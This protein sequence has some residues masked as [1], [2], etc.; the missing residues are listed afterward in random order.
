[1]SVWCNE[2]WLCE[3]KQLKVLFFF[4]KMKQRRSWVHKTQSTVLEEYIVWLWKKKEN[5]PRLG[6]LR[7]E[8]KKIEVR[9]TF[10][11]KCIGL[12]RMI[13]GECFWWDSLFLSMGKQHDA[14]P[15][16]EELFT[17]DNDRQKMFLYSR[18]TEN[19][20]LCMYV[21][22][23]EKSMHVCLCSAWQ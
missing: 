16:W 23:E 6:K 18:V 3:T 8:F 21:W 15:P 10:E 19:Y 11:H 13:Q 22:L 2:L 14:L 5:N 1:M 17:Q 12:H 4:S 7:W 9:R 20:V